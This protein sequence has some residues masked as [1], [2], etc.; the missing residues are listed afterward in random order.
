MHELPPAG[1]GYTEGMSYSYEYPRPSLTVDCVVFS[2]GDE[3]LLVLLI[4]RDLDPFAGYWA[5]PGGFVEMEES[6]DEAAHRE[7]RE[8]TGVSGV[9]LEQLHTFG[10]VDRDPRGRVVSVAYY[11]WVELAE[12]ELEAATDARQA[13]W[14]PVRD[15]PPL[16]FDH[17]QI[18]RLALER[19]KAELR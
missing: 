14:F 19:V 16:A 9:R 10:A 15:T 3:D 12:H 4:Q 1:C 18:V 8:E 13:G 5:L 11:G 6:L 7:L 2:P 17:Q